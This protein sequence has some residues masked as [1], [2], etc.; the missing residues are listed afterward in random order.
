MALAASSKPTRA[1]VLPLSQGAIIAYDPTRQTRCSTLVEG[2]NSGFAL[3]QTPATTV[4]HLAQARVPD[5]RTYQWYDF[6]SARGA[7]D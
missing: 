6:C 4:T 7:I 1:R 2:D 5:A 3:V